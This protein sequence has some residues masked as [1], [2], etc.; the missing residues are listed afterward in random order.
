MVAYNNALEMWWVF[1]DV[2][3]NFLPIVTVK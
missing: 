1:S 3:T 2:I